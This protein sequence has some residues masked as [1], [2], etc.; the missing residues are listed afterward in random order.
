MCVLPGTGKKPVR[1]R[2]ALCSWNLSSR[3]TRIWL[4]R[5]FRCH[6]YARSQCDQQQASHA[7]P[8]GELLNASLSFTWFRRNIV[9]AAWQG[10]VIGGAG[11]GEADGGSGG[12]GRQRQ[13]QPPERR[14]RERGSSPALTHGGHSNSFRLCGRG[15]RRAIRQRRWKRRRWQE[16]QQKTGSSSQAGGPRQQGGRPAAGL[17][18]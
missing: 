16:A 9:R 4:S 5:D 12:D 15:D 13:H 17:G 1:L 14:Q 8:Q 18:P 10:A 7:T 11:S 2:A 6:S 3:P